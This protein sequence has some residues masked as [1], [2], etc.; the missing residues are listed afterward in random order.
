MLLNG[1]LSGVQLWNCC[2]W[3]DLCVEIHPPRGSIFQFHI[4]AKT[5]SFWMVLKL[6]DSR[7]KSNVLQVLKT[8]QEIIYDNLRHKLIQKK[9]LERILVS[10]YVRKTKGNW[11]KK[12]QNVLQPKTIM[13]KIAR[14]SCVSWEDTLQFCIMMSTIRDNMNVA[15]GVQWEL[16]H[17]I[18]CCFQLTTIWKTC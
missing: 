2:S 6:W 7:G 14:M 9:K 18:C 4:F 12:P 5:L 17:I 15:R 10:Q 8:I 11:E 16:K 13:P 3:Q 1:R